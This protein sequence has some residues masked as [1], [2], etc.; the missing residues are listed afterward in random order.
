MVLGVLGSIIG[1][2]GSSFLSNAT[3]KGAQ[4][5]A[6]NYARALAQQQY[7]LG[8]RGYKEAPTAQRQ[9]LIDA[10]YNPILALGNVGSGVSVSGG[11]PVNANATDTSGIKDAVTSLVNNLNQ[12]K[13]TRATV[14]NLD[15]QTGKNIAETTAQNIKNNFLSS[16][17]EA[18]LKK[19]IKE[20]NFMDAQ[21]AYWD[22]QLKM[23]EKLGQ[24]QY[25]ASIYGHN[26]AFESSKYNT[27]SNF[28]SSIYNS[29]VS[30]PFSSM[31]YNSL[32]DDAKTRQAYE[33]YIKSHRYRH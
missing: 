20:T 19:T 18:E 24:M 30:K 7:D 23:Q 1:S 2:V 28:S 33:D 25:N 22:S 3:S 26:K 16:R 21:V 15:S 29:T 14:D 27:D 4:A 13:Q 11:T 12:T 10:G 9:G 8:I 17:E 31:F 32:F 5:R 6:Y